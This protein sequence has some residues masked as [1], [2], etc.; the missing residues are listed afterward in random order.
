MELGE[1]VYA[2][3]DFETKKYG[4]VEPKLYKRQVKILKDAK[5]KNPKLE[6]YTLDYWNPDDEDGIKNIYSEQR[7]NGFSPYVATIDL[8]KIIKEP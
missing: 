1:S 4:L 3:Y 2:D 8:K 7:K 6:I 5:E